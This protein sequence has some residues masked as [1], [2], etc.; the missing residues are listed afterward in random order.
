MSDLWYFGSI[1][2]AY[3]PPGDPFQ[4]DQQDI[5]SP[6]PVTIGD[7]TYTWEVDF[8]NDANRTIYAKTSMSRYEFVGSYGQLS[9]G[10]VA[11]AER[12]AL[13][14][15][16]WDYAGQSDPDGVLDFISIPGAVSVVFGWVLDAY[17]LQATNIM[18]EIW[19]V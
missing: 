19:A 15:S 13:G 3:S 4:T 8:S 5:T 17:I 2:T 16:L 12:D 6:D 9:S 7:L 1:G 11:Y 14:G 10:I 18:C